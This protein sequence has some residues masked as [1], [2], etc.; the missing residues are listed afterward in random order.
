[1]SGCAGST[2]SIAPCRAAFVLSVNRDGLIV[3]KPETSRFRFPWRVILFLLVAVMGFK[4][5][6]HAYIGPEAYAE[7]LARLSNGTSPNRQ[8]LCAP[9]RSGDRLDRERAERAQLRSQGSGA[10]PAGARKKGRGS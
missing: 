9:R 1:M 2:G 4:V 8:R 5:A 3:A 7:R 10:V 6:L